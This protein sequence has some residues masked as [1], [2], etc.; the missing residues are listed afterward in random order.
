MAS[1]FGPIHQVNQGQG[2]ALQT[3]ASDKP[4]TLGCNNTVVAKFLAGIHIGDM[5]LYHR[6]LDGAN[7]IVNGNGGVCISTGIKYN[8][9]AGKT[10]FMQFVY[11]FAFDVTL[12]IMKVNCGKTI[13]EGL[14]EYFK[15]LCPVNFRLTFAQQV[16]VRS[17]DDLDFHASGFCYDAGGRRLAR[18][19]DLYK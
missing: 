1:G 12:V 18:N 14:K 11:Q 3:E 7:G 10:N 5:H 19:N 15:R 8:P 4:G 6:H 13:D 9:I 17:V 16:E 2:I